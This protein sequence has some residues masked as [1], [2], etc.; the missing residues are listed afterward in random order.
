MGDAIFQLRGQGCSAL[1]ATV[2]LPK[3]PLK[4]FPKASPLGNLG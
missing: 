1:I 2:G 3:E 4:N